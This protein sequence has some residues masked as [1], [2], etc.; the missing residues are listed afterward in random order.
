MLNCLLTVDLGLI[1][2]L[3]IGAIAII[4]VIALV[5]FFIG[6]YNGLIQLKNLVEEAWATIDVQLKKRYDLIPNLVETVKGYAAHESKTLES[7]IA[8]RN[9][10]MTASG[11][12]K[13][14]AENA[15]SGT[16]K[17]LF[18]LQESY[19]DLKANVNFMDLQN[20]LKLIENEIAS[21]RRYYNGTVKSFNDKVE[22]FPSNLVASMMKLTKRAY[23]ELDSEEERKNVKVQF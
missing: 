13:M 22:M 16:L 20:Q 11:D 7:V 1:I 15:L 2:G 19:P 4:A 14:A 21:A 18:A 3:V 8:A 10:A 5:S 6:T 9:L 12:A 23:F 17:S